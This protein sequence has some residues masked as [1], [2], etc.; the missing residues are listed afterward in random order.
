LIGTAGSWFFLDVAFYRLSL[1][2]SAIL[3]AIGY[4][5]GS[6]VCQAPFN[7]AVGNAIIV[8]A[9]TVPGYWFTVAFVD[10]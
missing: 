9:G 2:N 7:N 10:S 4:S 5:G 3:S 8:G 6:N 1:N